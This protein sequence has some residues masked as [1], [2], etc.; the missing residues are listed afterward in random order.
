M[1]D[2]MLIHIIFFNSLS[3]INNHKEFRSLLR[4]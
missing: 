1:D 4:T 3:F 2:V